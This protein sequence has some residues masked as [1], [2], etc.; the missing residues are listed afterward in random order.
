MQGPVA[1][2]IDDCALLLSAIAGKDSRVPI[3]ITEAGERFLEPLEREF[4]GVNVAWSPSLGGLPVDPR[5]TGVLESQRHVFDHLGCNVF[6]ADPDFTDADELF[7]IWR[8]WGREIN[9]GEH[10]RNNRDKLKDTMIWDIEQGVN[11]T[12]PQVGWAEA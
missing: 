8:G 3:S 5:T 7:L 12:G 10:L 11:L 9:Q 4:K 6:E 1:R 2:N